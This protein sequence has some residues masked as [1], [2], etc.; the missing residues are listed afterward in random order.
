M[1]ELNDSSQDRRF[2][3]GQYFHFHF[4]QITQSSFTLLDYYFSLTAGFRPFALNFHNALGGGFSFPII[5]FR[6]RVGRSLALSPGELRRWS[7]SPW[8][9]FLPDQTQSAICEQKYS[10]NKRKELTLSPLMLQYRQHFLRMLCRY[11][12]SK[13]C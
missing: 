1:Q 12:Y 9:W 10:S 2:S 13:K 4:F 11:K 5:C 3:F 6:Q 7:L 8:L